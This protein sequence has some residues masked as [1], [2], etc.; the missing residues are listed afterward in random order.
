MSLTD[1][2]KRF[3]KATQS[4]R[5]ARLQLQNMASDVERDGLQE[6]LGAKVA[7]AIAKIDTALERL[8]ELSSAAVAGGAVTPELLQAALRALG[9]VD[10]L[11]QPTT[12]DPKV[13]A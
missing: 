3:L 8:G 7:N 4:L 10:D 5:L 2:A 9:E 13:S 6:I 11:T 1:P 12:P